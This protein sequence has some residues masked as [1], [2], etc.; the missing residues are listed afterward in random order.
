MN[1]LAIAIRL[2]PDLGL[3]FG[4]E[5]G[6]GV[7]SRVALELLPNAEPLAIA[8]GGEPN[9]AI[10]AGGGLFAGLLAGLL[11]IGGGTVLVPMLVALGYA[12]V[13]AVATSSLSIAVTSLSG[14]WQNWRMGYL[15]PR[16]VLALGLPAL[17]TAQAGVLLADR[18]PPRS[19]LA[20][21]G[22]LLLLTVYLTGLRRR[23][24]A[25]QVAAAGEA[26]GETASAP[27]RRSPVLA[28]VGT[29]GAAGVLAG[30]FGVGGGVILVPLQMLLL[31]VPIKPAIQTSLGVIVLT[32]LSSVAGHAIA[33]NVVWQA[34]LL[35]GVGGLL[36]AQL[37]TRALPKLPDRLAVALFRS[38]LLVLA[39]Y[40]FWQAIGQ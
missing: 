26:A 21:F 3:E 33:G 1:P 27:G 16:R 14:S 39:A 9:W 6:P 40:A 23:L 31:D 24:V 32:A 7:V 5:L 22:G 8:A 19:L 36:G 20:A 38:L 11:G 13:Q 18:L 4:A 2:F 10:L 12:P 37:S 28:R 15:R 35:L 30:L 17:V 25:R 29:G 34:G